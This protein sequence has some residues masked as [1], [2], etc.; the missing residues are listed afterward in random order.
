MHTESILKGVRRRVARW[1]S[2]IRR[3]P[4]R[5]V[6]LIGALAM[7]VAAAIGLGVWLLAK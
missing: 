3:Q 1:T 5:V 6:I 4:R 7:I 2:W